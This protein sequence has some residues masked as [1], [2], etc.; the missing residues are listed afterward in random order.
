MKKEK[1]RWFDV[2]SLQTKLAAVMGVMILVIMVVNLF[3]YSRTNIMVR[4]IDRVF[5]SNVTIVEL[6]DGIRQVQDNVHE[7]LSTKSTEALENYYRYEENYHELILLLNDEIVDNP[8]KILEKNIREMSLSYLEKADETVQAKRG[9]NIEKYKAS[10]EELS[11][12]YEYIG[13]YIYQ[14]NSLQFELNS[15][16]YQFLL[17][18]MG[19]MEGFSLVIV[20]C[21]FVICLIIAIAIIRSMFTP[22]ID[23]SKAARSVAKGN[24][25]VQPP[26][27][28][29]QDEI[30]VVT[31]TFG[32]M[33]T[34]INE[35]I[36]RLKESMEE[37]GRLKQNELAMEAHLKEAQLRFLQAQINPHFLF[38][39][40][41]AGAQLA[42]MEDAEDTGVFL[43][44]MAEFFRYNVKKTGVAATLD[45]EI[46]LVDNYI[47]ILNVRFAGDIT[48]RKEIR[49]STE[50]IEIPS[51]I[52]QPV[53]ENSVSHGIRDMLDQGVISMEIDRGED[54]L[55][56]C[57]TDNGAGIS[58]ERLEQIYNGNIH[59]E[60]DG[61]TGIGLINVMN[62]LEIF[63]GR[64]DLVQIE[65]D[66]EGTGTRVIIRIPQ[67]NKEEEHVQITDS[68]R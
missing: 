34:S 67:E 43:E 40:L 20:L 7:Y 41:N 37:K 30:G 65:S 23:L 59:S 44:K 9:R 47:Y 63:Y 38:N 57:V 55:W 14:W 13:N 8:T 4:Q 45:E 24:F 29:S 54:G 18:A 22:L 25:D 21:I 32:Q 27:V 28:V 51:M 66:G 5:S 49:T 36:V 31:A 50:G 35:Y 17:N 3:I 6:R 19:V 39:S 64:K 26:A 58:Q 12:L 48:Y 52:L 33:L 46:A 53:V 56:I 60:E 68:G 10:Y 61:S 16:N 62:R 1:R 2:H 15:E 42:M 11:E